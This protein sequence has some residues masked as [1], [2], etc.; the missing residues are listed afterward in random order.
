MTDP[1]KPFVLEALHRMPEGT[2]VLADADPQKHWLLSNGRSWALALGQNITDVDPAVHA[3][4]TGVLFVGL[5]HGTTASVLPED[6]TI[7]ARVQLGGNMVF[8]FDHGDL[9]LAEGELEVAIFEAGGRFLWKDGLADILE[10]ADVTG[11][12]V[13]ELKDA[14][15]RVGRF[16][17]RTG[18]PLSG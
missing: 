3:A 5:Y 4:K 17:L 12:G 14:S 13:L 2:P 8:W 15:G 16:D 6:G 10:T 9:I 11:D 7:A 1:P 18:R